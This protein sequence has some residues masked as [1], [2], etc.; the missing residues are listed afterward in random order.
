MRRSRCTRVVGALILTV[1]AFTALPAQP[2]R[3]AACSPSSSSI[4]VGGVAYTVLEFSATGSCDWVVPTGVTTI[5]VLIVGG[6][7]GASTG[8]GGGGGV[9]ALSS[10]SVTPGATVSVVVGAG[11]VGNRSRTASGDL[12]GSS[13]FDG[14]TAYGGGGGAE[15]RAAATNSSTTASNGGNGSDATAGQPAVTSGQG[16]LGGISRCT[17]YGG[18]GGGGGAGGAG[19]DG[20]PAG[21]PTP[22]ACNSG[23]VGSYTHNPTY[24]GDGGDGI[25]SSITGASVEYGAGGGGGVNTN[26]GD[27]TTGGLGGSDDAGD[28]ARTAD[29]KGSDAVDGTG[30]GGGGGDA[31]GDGGGDGGNGVVIV[32][33]TSTLVPAFNSPTSTAD[34]FTVSATNYDAN[35]SWTVTTSAGSGSIDSAGLITVTGLSAGS[36]ATATVV[37]S[38]SGYANGSATVSGTAASS[39]PTP[40]CEVAG[41]P[42][43][44]RPWPWAVAHVD[45]VTVSWEALIDAEA[46]SGGVTAYR[47]ESN[48][49]G[50]TCVLRLSEVEPGESLP[51]TCEIL[52]LSRDVDYTFIVFASSAFGEGPGRESRVPVRLLSDTAVAPLPEVT[53]EGPVPEVSPEAGQTLPETGSDTRL[54]VAT[55]LLSCG[56]LLS[57]IRPRRVVGSGTK[58]SR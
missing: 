43:A 37:T 44:V 39:T 14:T 48:P 47:V 1:A 21:V 32:R 46:G 29:G 23:N 8:G 55:L 36:S 35:F 31:E 54:R 27:S 38:R 12:G 9:V 34:G 56:A 16:N 49:A 18:A 17:F 30:A 57:L 3:A 50:G 13:S 45:R 11:G 52:G 20:G 40:G 19:T 7:G 22:S 51:T 5:D 26:A 4:E 24:G 42:C 25:T 41:R 58:A 2:V 53:P 33:Y 6:G 10:Q 15:F 28:G